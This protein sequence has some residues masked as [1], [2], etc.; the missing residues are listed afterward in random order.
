[1]DFQ[2]T[3]SK[4][5][6]EERYELA[7]ERIK[8]IAD[9][10]ELSSPFDAY[11][12]T[13]SKFILFVNEKDTTVT[14]EEK[15]A[16]NHALYEDILPE[17]YEHSYG[18]PTFAVKELGEEFGQLLCFLYAE[19]RTMIHYSYE[20]EPYFITILAELWIE[21]YN[22]FQQACSA[23]EVR[24]A[25]Y[26]Y[27]SDYSDV[28][29][30]YRIKSQYTPTK[31]VAKKILEQEDFSDIRYLYQYGEWIGENEIAAAMYLNSLPKEEIEEMATT[32]T[33]GF[34]D[35]YQLARLD[36][37]KKKYVNIRYSIGF[38]RIVAEAMKQFRD[39][40]L[41]AVIYPEGKNTFHKNPNGRVGYLSTEPNR[42]YSYD[43]KHDQGIYL[44]KAMVERKLESLKEALKQCKEEASLFAGPAVM[45]VFGEEPFTPVNKKEAISLDET[46]KELNLSYR[47]KSGD[48]LNEALK[49][50]E[51]SF[52]IIAYPIKEVGEP[53]EEIFH[54]VR[55][56]NTLD[57]KVY[58]TV[59]EKI[60]D[61]LNEG[62]FVHVTGK[63]SNQTDIL[64]KLQELNNKEKE[65]LFENCLADVNIPLG[66]VF[67]TPKLNGTKGVL[68]VSEVYLND[69][70]YV[71]LTLTFEDGKISSY[72]C[73]NFPTEEE[74]RDYIKTNLLQNRETLPL[75][76]F[77]IGT[78]TTAYQMAKKYQILRKLP[79]LIVEKMGPHFAVGDTCY[80]YQEDHHLYNPDGK[81]MIAKDNECSIL[82]KSD[83]SKAYFHCHTDI[84]IPYDEIDKITVITK[85]GEIPIIANGR[86]VLEG[87]ELLNRCL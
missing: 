15:Q 32:F 8:E 36:M 82:R 46:Q 16:K 14:L 26:W 50:E 3:Q 21:I 29:S 18:N 80:S 41:E 45:E 19:I 34:Y 25:I 13:V 51:T 72:T 1:M 12:Q 48:M 61:A 60:I 79:I 56:V 44:D 81:E 43:H 64:V 49:R 70:K 4:E 55:K 63:G 71:D 75:G 57:K 30:E 35:G 67:T 7:M 47:V 31:N 77:A 24:A 73:S 37:K 9:K 74:N 66:E 40:G 39:M 11:F 23:K 54:E 10:P 76:E 38:E 33:K 87:T 52:T 68:H 85:E 62:S 42:Q 2:T 27:V 59:Q 53:Y 28:M 20:Q 58:Q 6:I 22:L 5:W 65:T 69:L 78:N 83:S 17:N 84:T 86:F